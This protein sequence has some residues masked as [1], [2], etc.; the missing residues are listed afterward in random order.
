MVLCHKADFT[1][2]STVSFF[3]EREGVLLCYVQPPFLILFVIRLPL[4]LNVKTLYSSV[5]NVQCNYSLCA[6]YL[7]P[8]GWTTRHVESF[9][10]FSWCVQV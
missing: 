3:F 10:G 1:Y 6:A 8:T 5:I 7:K 4:M 2:I 9:C